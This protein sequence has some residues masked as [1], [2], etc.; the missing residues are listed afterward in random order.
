MCK[1][2]LLQA[3]IL[4]LLSQ[5]I[6]KSLVVVGYKPGHETRY[7][8][9][10]TIRQYAA[11]KIE[12][13]EEWVSLCNRHLAYF[14]HLAEE[15]EPKFA[16]AEQAGCMKQLRREQANLRRAL[17]WSLIETQGP[18]AVEGLRM[19]SA[20]LGFW[21]YY[22]LISEGYEW[23]KKGLELTD[24]GEMLSTTLQAKALCAFGVIN[25]DLH[26]GAH[27]QILEKSVALYRKSGDKAGLSQ[28]LCR[29]VDW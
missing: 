9:L 13:T 3:D 17:S 26:T 6:N 22:G 10:E 25:H 24:Q 27:T 8:L 16:T 12:G 2:C 21:E 19:A 14:L 23:L 4:D 15:I 18:L 29:L 5:L 7:R 1:F 28:A 11:A 20:L